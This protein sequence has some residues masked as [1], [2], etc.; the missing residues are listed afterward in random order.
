MTSHEDSSRVTSFGGCLDSYVS[1]E[2]PGSAKDAVKSYNSFGL[3]MPE[4][5]PRGAESVAAAISVWI[6]SLN[7]VATGTPLQDE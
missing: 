4:E 5:A 1:W 7:E 6:T 3:G 2:T